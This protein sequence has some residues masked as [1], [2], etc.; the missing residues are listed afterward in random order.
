MLCEGPLRL[1][2]RLASVLSVTCH[3]C[4]LVRKKDWAGEAKVS[5]GS[6]HWLFQSSNQ[7]QSEGK[8]L[9]F[10]VYML[11]VKLCIRCDGFMLVGWMSRLC[12]DVV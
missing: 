1:F 4:V 10:F 3:Y 6:V 12:A 8:I 5:F 2:C 11:P 7:V 9:D